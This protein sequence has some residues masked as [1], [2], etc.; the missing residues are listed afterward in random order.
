MGQNRVGQNDV[1]WHHRTVAE[2]LIA[3]RVDVDLG[4]DADE[5]VER[6]ALAGSNEVEAA[7]AASP[8]P[9]LARQFTGP[10]SLILFVA[11]GVSALVGEYLDAGVIGVIIV[12]NG[13]L[14]FVQEWRASKAI[15]AMT[16]MLV[17]HATV[18]R[19]GAASRVDASELVP[20]DVVVLASGDQVPADLRLVAA[21]DLTIDESALTGESVPVTKHPD[22]VDEHTPLAERTPMAYVGT[23]VRTG[24]GLGVVCATGR[25]TE[26]GNVVSLTEAAD[27]AEIPL[28][29]TLARLGRALGAAGVSVAL[30]TVVVGI[31]AGRDATEMLLIGISLAVA[32]VPEGLPAVVTLTLALGIRS[33]ARSNALLRRLEAAETLGAATVICTDKTGTLTENRMTVQ[34]LWQAERGVVA[35]EDLGRMPTTTGLAAWA[36]AAERCNHAELGDDAAADVGSPT[37]VALLRFNRRIGVGDGSG[38]RADEIV[39]ELPF[40]SDRKMMAVVT[41]HPGGTRLSVKGAPEVVLA[42]CETVRRLDGSTDALDDDGRAEVTAAL[43]AMTARALRTLAVASVDLGPGPGGVDGGGWETADADTLGAAA[44]GLVLEG[45]AGLHDPPRPEVPAAVATARR[46]GVKVVMMTGDAAATAA[47]IAHDIGLPAGRDSL[48]ASR[49]LTGGDLDAMGDRDLLDAVDDEVVLARV[50]PHHKMRVVRVLQG[51]GHVVAMT[52]DGVNDAPALEQASIGVAMGERGTDVA[53]EAADVVLTDDNFASIVLAV[54]E[55]RRQFANIT[56]F[57]RY[58][59]SS[60]LGEVVAVSGAVALGWPLILTPAQILWMNLVTD[61][62]T[63]LALGVEQPEPDA[64]DRPPRSIDDGPLDRRGA[65]SI[66]LAGVAIGL[67]SLAVFHFALEAG[68]TEPRARTLAFTLMVMLEIANVLNFRAE[69]QSL[70]RVGWASNRILLAAMGLS[71]LAQVAAVHIGPLARALDTEPLALSEWLLLAAAGIPLVAAGE[72]VKALGRARAGAET[73]GG[74]LS[75]E[76]SSA[77]VR[78]GRR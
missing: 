76:R 23:H 37:E 30:L 31:A 42:R 19:E 74:R 18:R 50:A 72:A 64:M 29:R 67:A 8:W 40:D 52:G 77:R 20:G 69:R 7:G 62:A 38:G 49:V 16:A 33:L 36:A 12:A 6:R 55:G 41:E 5:V 4:L 61:G 2:T 39:A 13:A 14:G 51:A 28:Q 60:N 1:G 53:R 44:R 45:I 48:P 25:A 43:A 17:H 68:V 35:V 54:G 47:A 65:T 78:A 32:V 75:P 58:L 56:K 3:H 57:V 70:W 27:D 10:L 34:S 46:A 24:R 63:A 66:L 11:V 22:P 73:R 59:L 26:F 15:E 71:V 21:T 9:I